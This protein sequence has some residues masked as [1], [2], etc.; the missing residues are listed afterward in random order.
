MYAN[1]NIW[2]SL[3]HLEVLNLENN[4]LR[5]LDMVADLVG[6]KML[7]LRGNQLQ[8]LPESFAALTSLTKVS[9]DYS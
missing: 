1:A 3:T 2:H 6:L 7:L 5:E 8:T 4:L 9:L